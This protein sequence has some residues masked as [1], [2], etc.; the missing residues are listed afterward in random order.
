MNI[1][2]AT[3][4]LPLSLALALALPLG[5]ASTLAAA[6][7]AG[8][9]SASLLVKDDIKFIEEANQ[10]GLLVVKKSELVLKRKAPGLN[11]DFAQK[12]VTGHLALNKELLE[13]AARKGVKLSDTLSEDMQKKYDALAKTDDAKLSKEYLDYQVKEH[14]KAVGAFKD[15]ADDSKDPEVKAFAVKHLPH[16]QAH[17]DEVKRIEEAQ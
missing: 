11:Q 3:Y 15:A 8:D 1:S 6:D 5:T 10:C 12:M 9:H 2:N 14:K 4:A 13:L 17:L 16:L 7:K